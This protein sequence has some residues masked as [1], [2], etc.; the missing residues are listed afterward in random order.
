MRVD[1]KHGYKFTEEFGLIPNDWEVVKIRNVAQIFGRIGFRGYTKDDIVSQGYGAISL[2]PTNIKEN[3]LSYDNNTYISWYKYEESPEIKIFN[4]DI[5]LV[6]T[7]SSYGKSSIVEHLPQEATINPQLIVFKNLKANN[8]F[9]SYILKNRN[10]I[11]QIEKIVVG[12]AIPTLSQEQ[13]YSFNII[14]PPL[15][16]Q[17]KIAE[18]LSDVDSLIDKTLGLINKKKNLKTATMQKL[19]TPKDNWECKTLGEITQ[20]IYQPQTI[21]QDVFTI[22]GYPVFG[23]NGK[24]GLYSDYNHEKAQVVV[25]CRGNSCGRI[26]MTEPYSWITGNAMVINVDNVEFDKKFLFYILSYIDLSILITGSG[27]PQIVR[28]NLIEIKIFYPTISEQQKIATIL[29][30]MDLEIEMLQKELGKYQDLKIGIMQQLL[31]G[32]VRLL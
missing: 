7:G 10:F 2:S 4:G 13:I 32:K 1:K 11:E 14:Y 23:A 25:T 5:L 12:G 22:S 9:F 21:S 29:S 26:N 16:E 30:D 28:N 27:Q 18:V 17:E 6:K 15:P 3:G 24:I 20:N 31:T 19:L 8:K